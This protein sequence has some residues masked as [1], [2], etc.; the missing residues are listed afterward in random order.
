[1]LQDM[2]LVENPMYITDATT[3]PSSITDTSPK[4]TVTAL[5][6]LKAAGDCVRTCFDDVLTKLKDYI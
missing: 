2:T 4:F 1:M 3:M 6:A 5:K